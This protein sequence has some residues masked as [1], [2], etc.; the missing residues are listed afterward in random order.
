MA[1]ALLTETVFVMDNNR[2]HIFDNYG[3]QQ[4]LHDAL[5]VLK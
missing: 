5:L 3:Q 1:R 2:I 4:N